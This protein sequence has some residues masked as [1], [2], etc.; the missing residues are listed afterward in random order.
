MYDRICPHK[1]VNKCRKYLFTQM[2][3]TM[4]NDPTTPDTTPDVA[5]SSQGNIIVR[6]MD[7]LHDTE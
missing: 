5:G 6:H 7:S 4:D 1:T 2:N 3:Q